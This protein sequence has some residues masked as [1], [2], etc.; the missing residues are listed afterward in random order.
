MKLANSGVNKLVGLNNGGNVFYTDL[1]ANQ[2]FCYCDSEHL[3]SGQEFGS[4][5]MGCVIPKNATFGSKEGVLKLQGAPGVIQDDFL[6]YFPN[7]RFKSLNPATSIQ[8][9]TN[10][11]VSDV[12]VLQMALTVVK[13]FQ[14][15][16]DDG[17]GKLIQ[18]LIRHGAFLS[19]TFYLDAQ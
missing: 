9:N 12:F 3:A 8:G 18:I 13:R 7:Q 10:I 15:L 14:G 19:G 17:V 1:L 6:K 5:E 4:D 11:N 16:S 2:A